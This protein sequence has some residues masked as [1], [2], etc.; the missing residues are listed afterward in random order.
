MVAPRPPLSRSPVPVKAPNLVLLNESRLD[1]IGNRRANR[2]PG[3]VCVSPRNCRCLVQRDQENAGALGEQTR[4]RVAIGVS[5]L[6]MAEPQTADLLAA[7]HNGSQEAWNSLVD[8]Y[9]RL[10]WSVVRGFRLDAATAADVSQT[11]WLRLIE[12]SESHQGPGA[13]WLVAGHHR[14]QRIH[15]GV[16]APGAKHPDRIQIEVVDEGAPG[17][18]ERLLEDEQLREVLVAFEDISARCRRAAPDALSRPAS[19]VRGDLGRCSGW[20][21]EAS[22][23][24]GL[25]AWIGSERSWSGDE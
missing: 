2:G 10:V 16:Q 19:R 12:H 20:Q 24:Q 5:S 13:S 9:G 8:R 7:A 25:A 23:R 3:E 1:H 17:I 18:D 6:V 4:I 14:P 15:P 22:G 11:V 21:S